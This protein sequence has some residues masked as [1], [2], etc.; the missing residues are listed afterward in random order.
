MAYPEKRRRKMSNGNLTFGEFIIQKR[1]ERD[2]PARQLAMAL[3]IS[4]VYMCDIEK[5][6]KAA[7]SNDFLKELIRIL[8][9]DE[10][11]AARMYDLAAIARNTV[12]A[13]LPEYIMENELVR[14]ALRSA[15]ENNIPDEK[16]ERFINEII[17][18]E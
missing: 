12:S 15:K 17:L 5:G 16:W 4:A 10:K 3:N 18:K 9:L 6:R 11:D 13:D 8:R 14:T 2:I 7:V 1:K